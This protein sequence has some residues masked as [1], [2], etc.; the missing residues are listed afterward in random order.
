M[1]NLAI[2]NNS[3]RTLNNLYSLADLHRASGNDPKHRPTYFL[4]N[5]Q[6]KQKL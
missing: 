2:L 5:D 4:R 3:I 1:T 6:I